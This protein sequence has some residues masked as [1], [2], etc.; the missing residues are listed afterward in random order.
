M[1]SAPVQLLAY[2][3]GPEAAFQGQLVGALERLESG[4]ALR[5]LDLVFVRRDPDTG[6]LDALELGSAV[7]GGGITGPIVDF[8]LGLRARASET[9]R[10]LAGARGPELLALGERL[11]PGA[12]I[13]AVFVEHRWA[14]TLE[15]AVRRVGGTE[16]VNEIV[17]DDEIIRRLQ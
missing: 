2:E 14:E 12:A 3:F 17:D 6:E 16:V 5:I 11:A 8:R 13:A 7:G 4:G 15:D 9:E 1:S 10:A